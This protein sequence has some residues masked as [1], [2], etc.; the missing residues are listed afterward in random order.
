LD[1]L[2]HININVGATRAS[3]H[4]RY[5][6]QALRQATLVKKHLLEQSRI[7]LAIDVRETCVVNRHGECAMVRPLRTV[8]PERRT[9]EGEVSGASRYVR[10]LKCAE[11]VSDK[12]LSFIDRR[13]TT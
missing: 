1:K 9:V 8:D 6:V 4:K 5:S 11:K 13:Q 12:N 7:G 10:R 2:H 3:V